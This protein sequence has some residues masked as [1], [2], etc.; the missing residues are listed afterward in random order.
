MLSL[1]D[2]FSMLSLSVGMSALEF[3]G[4]HWHSEKF[5]SLFFDLNLSTFTP[6]LNYAK[7][8]FVTPDQAEQFPS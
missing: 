1:N 2:Y 6:N 5:L 7:W 8:V 4:S 3:L